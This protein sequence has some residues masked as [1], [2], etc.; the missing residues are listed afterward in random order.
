M[1][2]IIDCPICNFPLQASNTETTCPQCSAAILLARV[3]GNNQG[4][5]VTSP[6]KCTN[7]WCKETGKLLA[8]VAAYQPIGHNPVSPGQEM[9]AN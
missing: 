8:F 5:L 2:T 1:P 7:I 3:S 6:C 9:T 4:I